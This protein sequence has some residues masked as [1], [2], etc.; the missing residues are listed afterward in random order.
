M[1]EKKR[2]PPMCRIC[3]R[4]EAQHV[5][6]WYCQKFTPRKGRSAV[7]RNV[8]TM[9]DIRALMA[10]AFRQVAEFLEK[11]GDP[12][13]AAAGLA[14]L[15]NRAL[16]QGRPESAPPQRKGNGTHASMG[17][18]GPSPEA[19]VRPLR[20]P[21]EKTKRA[22]D[23]ELGTCERKILTVL[24][25]RGGKHTSAL[26]CALLAGYKLTGSFDTALATLRATGF[27]IG[28]NSALLLTREGAEK[29][30]GVDILLA[31]QPALD[32]W[33]RKLGKCPGKILDVLVR[34]YPDEVE[35]ETIAQ[36]TNYRM[37]GSFDTA[38]AGLRRFGVIERE[39][40]RAKVS[41]EAS[42]VLS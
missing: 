42:E 1:T 18:V 20:E 7:L 41:Q 26:Q 35:V 2:Q 5:P 30:G 36:R 9:D 13:S 11:G 29:A 3:L 10:F 34:E 32:Y 38:L 25:M 14:S 27:V 17:A 16:D 31:G 28:P 23:G 33:K 40:G 6:G 12:K 15:A 37:T 4:D 24:S 8:A 21:A 19:P 22:A 39:H